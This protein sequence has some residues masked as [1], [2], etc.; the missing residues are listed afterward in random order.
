ML[1][2]LLN[3][4]HI[5]NL[6]ELHLESEKQ[7]QKLVSF[8]PDKLDF[9]RK[10]SI[11]SNIGASTRIENAVLT[12]IEIEWIDTAVVSVE[13]G[14][15]LAKA[16]PIKNKLS[17]DKERSIEEVAGYRE[18]LA[19]VYSFYQDYKKM[20]ESAIKGLHRELLKYYSI[21]DYHLGDYKIQS[22]SVVEK[23]DLT[24]K[25]RTIF[26]TADP[27]VITSTQMHDLVTWYSQA[28]DIEPWGISVAVEF[29]FRF[30]AI[31]P[32][33]DG[34]GRLSRLLFQLILLNSQDENISTI[35]PYIAIDRE[36]EKTRSEYYQVLRKCSEGIYKT[37]PAEYNYHY[38]L[39]YI[40]NIFNKSLKNID[41]YADKYDLYQALTE[42]DLSIYKAFKEMPEKSLQTKNL[43]SLLHIPRRTVIYALN[44]LVKDGFLQVLGAGA[45][46]KY[47]LAF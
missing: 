39:D 40:I 8:T 13:S 36:I 4:Q 1:S 28:A 9:I 16:E 42:T 2:Y 34:N 22:N 19:I 12:D 20:S 27:G 32:F 46:K 25:S 26:Q 41:Y 14:S 45:Q 31:H 5:Q 17:K 10:H 29:I 6:K 35:I 21:A 11:I 30:L 43:V 47:K 7:R 37:D 38:F 3:N 33:Q 44:K 18:A 15:Y 24:G 23:N